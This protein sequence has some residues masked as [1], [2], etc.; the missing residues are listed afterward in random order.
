[1]KHC[2]LKVIWHFLLTAIIILM[3]R[4]LITTCHDINLELLFNFG[5]TNFL[6]LW[7]YIFSQMW[8]VLC[9]VF[10]VSFLLAFQYFVSRIT[11]IGIVSP[12]SLAVSQVRT[13]RMIFFLFI[14]TNWVITFDLKFSSY[15]FL[16]QNGY[17]THRHRW[18]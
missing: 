14:V 16:S 6:N 4:H 11:M 12:L 3:V 8:K 1:M 18:F 17:I 15:F 13:L 5:F 10:K 9:H 7:V 2:P